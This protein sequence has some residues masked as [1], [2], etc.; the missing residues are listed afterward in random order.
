MFYVPIYLQI[1]EDSIVLQS[2]F[3]NARERLE[4]DGNLPS[5]A[6]SEEDEEEEEDEDQDSPKKRGRGPDKKVNV[7][8]LYF[9]ASM[10]YCDCTQKRLKGKECYPPCHNDMYI[11]MCCVY[12]DGK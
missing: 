6:Q 7:C 11:I 4:Q 5:P 3:T 2:V 1:Y 12:T 9:I 10:Y 8:T